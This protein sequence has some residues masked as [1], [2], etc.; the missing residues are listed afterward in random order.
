[1]LA[2]ADSRTTAHQ[3]GAQ[4]FSNHQINYQ[5]TSRPSNQRVLDPMPMSRA[6][7]LTQLPHAGEDAA[8]HSIQVSET[9]DLGG[10]CEPDTE[11]RLDSNTR[12]PPVWPWHANAD[13]DAVT[14]IPSRFE[15]KDSPP[16]IIKLEEGLEHTEL[17]SAVASR[18]GTIS[19]SQTYTVRDIPPRQDHYYDTYTYH[20]AL[21]Y[22]SH[23]DYSD[24]RPSSSQHNHIASAT[25]VAGHQTRPDHYLATP[26]TA[27]AARP[28][29]G[30][31][32]GPPGGHPHPPYAP[33]EDTPT[34][35]HKPHATMRYSTGGDLAILSAESYH[36]GPLN[37]M[38]SVMRTKKMGA[39]S[40]VSATE[41]PD[42]PARK[43][44]KTA[45]TTDDAAAA[46]AAGEEEEKKRSR[47]RPR[48]EPK[49]ETAQDV[50]P[51]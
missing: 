22:Q 15:R 44:R 24:R 19:S 31:G 38:A 36:D 33:A 6:A 46:A 34:N 8:S 5:P 17:A 40:P 14:T 47:G 11:R 23:S 49:D 51:L 32:T 37:S 12:P 28:A 26:S 16:L 9:R 48:L 29:P 18:S 27:F 39:G 13:S 45:S 21:G 3:Q 1:M 25:F 10:T 41:S 30:L 50:S 4:V 43:R 20:P 2:G 42:G 7:F 35:Q